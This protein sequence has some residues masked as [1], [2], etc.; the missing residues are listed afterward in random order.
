MYHN[1][2]LRT[3]ANTNRNTR[4]QRSVISRRSLLSHQHF[5]NAERE[6]NQVLTSHF[7][8]LIIKKPLLTTTR[9][10]KPSQKV[11][12]TLPNT[13]SKTCLLGCRGVPRI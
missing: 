9:V 13:L 12:K 7:P 4:I 5:Q 3:A 2:Q 1:P 6:I 11:P 8:A 10:M